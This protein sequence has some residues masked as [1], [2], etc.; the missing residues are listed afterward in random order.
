MMN[1]PFLQV[2]VVPP[3][4]VAHRV[5]SARAVVHNFSRGIVENPHDTLHQLGQDTI[6]F[7]IKVVAALVIYFVGAW[8]IRRIRKMM[9]KGF[10]RRKTEKTLA[11]FLG[12]LVSIS[13]TILLIVMVIATL[14]INTTSLAALL[15]AGGMAIGMALSGT[16]QNFAGGIMILIFKPFK[17]GD[18]IEAQG[19]QGTVESVTIVST[20]L[21]TTDNRIIVLPNGA[22][23]NGTVNNYNT[24]TIRRVE[25]K[26]SLSYGTDADAALAA[27]KKIASADPRLLDASTPG[28]AD[29][30][31]ALGSMEDSAVVFIVRAWVRSEDY[32]NVYFD[33]NRLFYTEL[34][35]AGFQFP[36]PQ[37]DV[38]LDASAKDASYP[39]APA[40]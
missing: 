31:A 9:Q 5:D 2:P 24:Q 12:S 11:S 6:Q 20:R 1:L 32:W 16:V 8:L 23:S 34:P 30:F 40:R 10:E 3:E 39:G 28:A 4:E 36:F 17:A 27:L 14:G 33:L 38:H 15:A 25:W 7:G 19:Y 21:R 22:L 26:I 37:L 35:K 13:L 18:Y 29:L